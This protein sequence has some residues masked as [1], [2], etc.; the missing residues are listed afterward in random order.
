MVLGLPIIG[1]G[2][3]MLITLNWYMQTQVE[4]YS[5]DIYNY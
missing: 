2:T 3:V 5:R 4:T 1:V